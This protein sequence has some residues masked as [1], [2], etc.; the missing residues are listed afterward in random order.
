M[1]K[2][3]ETLHCHT[4]NSDGKLT[5]Q[6]VLDLFAK[7]NVGVVAFTDHDALPSPKETEWLLAHRDHP[8]KWIIGC[9]LSSGWPKEVGGIGSNFHLVGLFTDPFNKALNQRNLFF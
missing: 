1:M 5:H 7:N 4:I 9:E 3:Y 2:P 8:T 6:E